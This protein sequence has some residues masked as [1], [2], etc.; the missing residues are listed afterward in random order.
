MIADHPGDEPGADQEQIGR[1][2]WIPRIPGLLQKLSCLKGPAKEEPHRVDRHQEQSP[3]AS[4]RFGDIPAEHRHPR[5]PVVPPSIHRR[6][7]VLPGSRWPTPP[8]VHRCGAPNRSWPRDLVGESSGHDSFL[9]EAATWLR[10]R[11]LGCRHQVPPHRHPPIG[12][13]DPGVCA[14]VPIS[15]S[16]S[17]SMRA[18]QHSER[19][20]QSDCRVSSANVSP[21]A[22]WHMRATAM[23]LDV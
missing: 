9:V 14:I 22:C 21:T 7:P 13:F 19:C 5:S 12:P 1:M 16:R 2:T 18:S 8:L 4:E 11:E 20:G 3:D 15:V 23:T 10:A 17:P 6:S